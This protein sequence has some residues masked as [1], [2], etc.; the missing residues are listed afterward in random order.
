MKPLSG[1]AEALYQQP[2]IAEL[3]LMLQDSHG[4]DVNLL[5]FSN[6]YGFYY[7]ELSEDLM[8]KA[9][10]LSTE[11]STQVVKPLRSVRRWLRKDGGPEE[12]LRNRVKDSELAAEY[13][14][15][16]R[17]EQLAVDTGLHGRKAN[18]EKT[19]DKTSAIRS[20]I[21]I[22]ISTSA[23]VVDDLVLQPLIAAAIEAGN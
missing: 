16:Y 17:L 9:S 8:T 11:W 20:N 10:D 23:V 12:L 1:Y 4:L 6:W 19:H 13:L 21:S 3:C 22:C 15:L 5:L 14:Q 7:G 2:G 18:R